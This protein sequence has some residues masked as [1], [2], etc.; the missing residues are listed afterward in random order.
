MN[1]RQAKR[2]VYRDGKKVGLRLESP[3]HCLRY[4][5]KRRRLRRFLNELG[6]GE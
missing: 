4:L 1:R 3:M 2:W 5:K 6:V